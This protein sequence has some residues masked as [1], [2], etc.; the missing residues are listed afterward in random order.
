M[1]CLCES[2]SVHVPLLSP[3]GEPR[4]TGQ[5]VQEECRRSIFT[6]VS[7]LCSFSVWESFRAAVRS[8]LH[9]PPARGNSLLLSIKSPRYST[10]SQRGKGRGRA[11]IR[12]KPSA[13][14]SDANSIFSLLFF[15]QPKSTTRS[16]QDNQFLHRLQS[17]AFT[18]FGAVLLS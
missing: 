5:G 6:S 15:D 14:Y 18:M 12:H 16:L 9:V 10:S 3:Y 7:L 2:R 4:A 8:L 13:R 17:L 1:I 11:V